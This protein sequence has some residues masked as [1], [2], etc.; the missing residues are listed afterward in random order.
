MKN[1]FSKIKSFFLKHPVIV[2][3]SVSA[4]I[5]IGIIASGAGVMALRKYNKA[6]VAYF[7]VSSLYATSVGGD[8]SRLYV[9]FD[10]DVSFD[11]EKEKAALSK[12][13]ISPAVAGEW[14]WYHSSRLVFIP[15]KDWPANTKYSVTLPKNLVDGKLSMYSFNF[16]SPNFYARLDSFDLEQDPLDPKIYTVAAEFYF[17][18][19]VEEAKFE[20][21]LSLK[22]DKKPFNFNVVY[23]EYK[24]KATVR[25]APV[26]IKEE[27]QLALITMAGFNGSAGEDETLDIQGTSRFFRLNEVDA[28]IVRN[29]QDEP[30]Q[31][32]F[33]NFTDSIMNKDMAGKVTAYLLPKREKN[34][35]WT[36]DDVTPEVVKTLKTI[37]L[38]SVPNAEDYSA[39]FSYR[40]SADNEVNPQI[41]VS[42]KSPLESRS[43]FKISKDGAFVVR[44]P[45]FPQELKV[46]GA[47]SLLSM[48]GSRKLGFVS[49][50]I[51]GIKVEIAR[52]LPDQINH[53]IT[54]TGGSFQQPY[55]TNYN[56]NEDNISERFEQSIPLVRSNQKANYSSANLSNYITPGKTGLFLLKTHGYDPKTNY[57]QTGT[58]TRFVLA[59][60]LGLLVKSDIDGNR[61]VYVMNTSTGSPVSG[62]KVEVL[63][64]NGVALFT[65]Y[66]GDSGYAEFGTLNN[67]SREKE[68]VVIVAKLGSDVSFIPFDRYNR[69]V[70]YS[71]FETEGVYYSSYKNK[72]LGA[73]MF[74]GRGIYRPG[75]DI[76]IGATVKTPDWGYVGGIPVKFVMQDPQGKNVFEKTLSLPADG[77]IDFTIPTLPTYV[78]GAYQAYL[79]DITDKK[80]QIQLGNTSVRVEEFQEDKL[81]VRAQILG[82]GKKG[83]QPM[84]GLSAKVTVENLFGTPAQGNGVRAVLSLQPISFRFSQFKDYSFV[85][86]NS[87]KNA[88]QIRSAEID[89]MDTDGNATGSDGTAAADIDLTSYSGGSYRINLIAEAFEQESGKSVSATDSVWVSPSTFIVGYKSAANL[90][91]LKRNADASVNFI[92][93]DPELVTLDKTKLKARVVMSQYVST[94]VKQYNGYKY[95]SVLKEEEK[96]VVPFEIKKAGSSFKLDTS[97]PGQYALEI[98]DEFNEKVARVEYFVSGSANLTYSLEKEAELKLTL[99]N[100]EAEPGSDLVV[101]IISPYKGAGLITIEREKVF[102]QKWFKSSTTSTQQTIR[103]PENFEGN[104]YINVSFMRG[105]DSDDIFSS[106]HSYAVIPFYVTRGKRT[107]N[108]DLNVPQ[109]VRP[110]DKLEVKYKASK[111]SKIIVYGASEGILQVA[112][113]QLP[114]PLDYF[115]RKMALEVNTWQIIDLILPDYKMISQMASAGGDFD[116]EAKQLLAANL[117]PFA[118]KRDKPVTFWSGVLDA[119]AEEKSYFY[120]VPDYFNGEIRVMAVAAS[121]AAAG[122]ASSAVT[123]QA[124][125]ILNSGAPFAVVPGDKFDVTL[126]VSNNIAGNDGK[127]NVNVVATEEIKLT[128][129][130]R[131]ALD[132]P[133]GA[134]KTVTFKAEALAKLGGAEIIFYAEHP[135]SKEK[136]TSR[137]TMSVR[138]ET[139]YT[140]VLNTGVIT[141]KS[142]EIDGFERDM[143]PFEAKRDIYLSN[144]PLVVAKGLARFFEAFPHGCSEQITSQVFPFLALALADGKGGILTRSEVEDS[145][146]KVVAKLRVRQLNNGSF[147][148]WDGGSYEDRDITLYIVRFLTTAKELGYNVPESMFERALERLDAYASKYPTGSHEA[149]QAA[150]AAY[151]LARNGKVVTTYLLRTQEYLDKNQKG[152]ENSL[153]GA[154]IASSYKLL[155]DSAKADGIIKQFK[156][157][158]DKYTFYSDY[159]SSAIRN[160]DYIELLG[161]H[162]PE[163]MEKVSDI[164]MPLVENVVNNNYNTLSAAGT[165]RALTAYAN[166]VKDADDK[167]QLEQ[168]LKNAKKFE[169]VQLDKNAPMP[170]Y[171]FSNDVEEFKAEGK[172]G[173]LGLFFVVSTQGFDKKGSTSKAKGLQVTKEYFNAAGKAVKTA[174]IGDELTV[175]IKIRSTAKDYVGNVAVIDLMPGA[176]EAISG[177]VRGDLDFHDFRED[178]AL[179]YLGVSKNIEEITYNVKVI[180]GGEFISPA[181]YAAALYDTDTSGFSDTTKFTVKPRN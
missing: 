160:A 125:I 65:K 75:D 7:Q 83:W 99:E 8:P 175:K 60:D 6:E 45:S 19:S 24:R 129:E 40:F 127:I 173:P 67:F 49:R 154:Y 118:R 115:F 5:V 172:G 157:E 82:G 28:E 13:K 122:S 153:T 70:D 102:A 138:P 78:T 11:T 179:L 91:Y 105:M 132:I 147:T 108:I 155:K 72:G 126:R 140:T 164:L 52:I 18:H 169:G 133:Y 59:T 54:Q 123:V 90:S 161:L 181:A 79:Y 114:K 120:D 94:L 81:R 142:A 21:A 17:S 16:A 178:R 159:D 152:W 29:E 113:Y 64:K 124:P 27:P 165:I 151:L 176:F 117:N 109:M 112:K 136:I 89:L 116:E 80:R 15:Q 38:T 2:V 53:F 171:A 156:P 23:D 87:R 61:R 69:R 26:T 143:F 56:F 128:G 85:D 130:T 92:A 158:S 84:T 42:V 163:R 10:R 111:A 34:K 39:V 63:G 134:E 162:F 68:P 20:K 135:A 96:S 150:R 50:G 66:T 145:F 98:V 106:P 31:I 170:H 97:S 119:G 51:D 30:E 12:I 110:G 57:M 174:T 180:A 148:M 36:L 22:I 1:L 168:K 73:F 149:D 141:K 104:G 86:M 144:S 4:L 3:C 121:A 167:I 107:V 76:N 131:A 32:L 33:V 43:G 48:G 74:S 139:A 95:Q 47:G 9:D 146:A 77:F 37:P 41:Y 103:V 46:V 177:S 101:N 166:T 100:S 62:A 93:V 25:S 55:F 44:A 14:T 35:S 137:A 71:R 88:S 58:T